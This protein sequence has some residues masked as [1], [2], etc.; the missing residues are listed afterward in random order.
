MRSL[1]RKS[2]RPR[3]ASY[4]VLTSLGRT[5]SFH[6]PKRGILPV[7]LDSSQIK[8]EMDSLGP[9][10]TVSRLFGAP[11]VVTEVV[12]GTL[13]VLM[14][15]AVPSGVP[16]GRVLRFEASAS[17]T[18]LPRTSPNVLGLRCLRSDVCVRSM[19]RIV[20]SEAENATFLGSSG[21]G[22]LDFL[23]AIRGDEISSAST[24]P[25]VACGIVMHDVSTLK[26]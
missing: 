14:V 20:F 11:R 10:L 22:D 24:R 3:A 26:L 25:L 9:N 12:P 7:V 13:A 8:S 6:V 1:V 18:A 15:P 23:P 2:V 17:L 16:V 21:D 4:H 5:F 19:S